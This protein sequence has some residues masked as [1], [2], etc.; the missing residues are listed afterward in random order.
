[1]KKTIIVFYSEGYCDQVAK[2]LSE[3]YQKLADEVSVLLINE[4]QYTSWG[5][6]RFK[7]G[8]YRFSMRYFPGINRFGGFIS[9]QY[10]EKF[11]SKS[12]K[13]VKETESQE[14]DVAVEEEKEESFKKIRTRFRKMDNILLRFNPD[15]VVCTTPVSLEKALKARERLRMPV[16]I[17]VAITDYCTNRGM[18]NHGVDKFLVQNAKIKQ[19]LST[20][21]IKD[22][23]VDVLGTP[24][25]KSIVEEYDRKTQLEAFGVTNKDLK[26]I[27]IVS[28][29]CGCARV[30][31]AFK[32]LAPYASEMNIFVMANDSR[33]IHSFVKT[34]TKASKSTD[35]IYVIDSMDDMA[36]LYSVIDVIVT[37][38]TA[39][40]TYEAAARGIPCVLLNP[41]NQLEEGNFQYLSTNGFAFIGEKTSHL[42]PTVLSLAKGENPDGSKLNIKKQ[43]TNAAKLYGDSILAMVSEEMQK[44][45]QEKAKSKKAAKEI[46]DE[47]VDAKV[48][49][50]KAEKA[51][52]E[53]KKKK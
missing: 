1:M 42:V 21:G 7:D 43:P 17:C 48:E 31:D 34:Y 4:A 27:L 50:K 44:K 9:Y 23:T 40:I 22:E 46:E 33:N 39:A 15:V 10:N 29:R 37:S 8:L 11:K 3:Y 45:K 30:I 6:R 28:G 52:K 25:C 13:N 12:S 47:I 19:T 18:I 2:A 5:S 53:T 51:K 41:A 16:Q 20:F 26:N 38:P 35:N 49:D 36:K 24:I 32:D 14:A